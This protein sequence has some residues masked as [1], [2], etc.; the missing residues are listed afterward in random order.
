MIINSADCY[1]DFILDDGFG[2]LL[3]ERKKGKSC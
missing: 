1:I 2:N 3:H